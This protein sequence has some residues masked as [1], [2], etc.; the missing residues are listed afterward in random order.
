MAERRSPKPKAG[1]SRPS[2]PANLN[3]DA[4]RQEAK[5]GMIKKCIQFGREV[6]R[7]IQKIS[8]PTQREIGI[9]TL[10]IFI[11]AAS[12]AIFFFFVD[13]GVGKII[14]VILGWHG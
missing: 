12:A 4:Q 9:T 3:G 6:Q 2:T 8:W 14:R 7:E 10:L 5:P 1:G 13:W 11:M